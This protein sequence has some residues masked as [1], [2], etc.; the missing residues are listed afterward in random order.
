MCCSLWKIRHQIWK[1]TKFKLL[2]EFLCTFQFFLILVG[3]IIVAVV[4]PIVGSIGTINHDLE[5]SRLA[6]KPDVPHNISLYS[7]I[8]ENLA[9][10]PPNAPE[11][12]TPDAKDSRGG[13]IKFRDY[14]IIIY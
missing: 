10:L 5:L 12:P 8:L 11:R 9:A 13:M 1:N 7:S 3:F 6:V 14:L 2:A 4:V